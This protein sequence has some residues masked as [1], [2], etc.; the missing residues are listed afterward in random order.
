MKRS[1]SYAQGR[2]VDGTGRPTD[3]LPRR[4]RRD[5]R[6]GDERRARLQGHAGVRPHASA[7]RRS[8]RMT[9][10]QR[11]RMLKAL[12]QYLMARKEEFYQRLRRHGATK[13]DSWIDIDGG[14]G[15]L[16]RL[17]EPRAPRV[18]RRDVLRRRRPRGADRKGG[19]FVGRHICVP[20]EGVAVHI[21][22]FNF[23]VLGDAGEAGADASSPACQPS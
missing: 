15:T 23:P 7:D 21:N 13:T 4:Y 18:S 8:G 10:H 3:A 11:A 16:L 20:L 17:R 6:R 2:W 19:T 5:D 12:A 22:A 1:Q 14:I 9:F